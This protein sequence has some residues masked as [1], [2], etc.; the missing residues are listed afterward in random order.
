MAEA[1][2]LP[3]INRVGV[4]APLDWLSLGW[5]DLRRAPF[6][7]L[8]YGAGLAVL[9]MAV[10]ATLYLTGQ[11]TW[12]LVLAGGF[13]II[14]PILGMGL[15]RAACQLERGETPSL[16]SMII[17]PG[18]L[19]TDRIML[20]VALFV[21]FG[22]WVEAA[23]IIYGLSTQVM[24]QNVFDFF[25]FLLMTPDGWQ[26]ALIGSAIGG[27]IAFLA[28]TVVVVSAPMLLESESDFFISVIS[29]ARAVLSNF[30]AML[31][32]ALII[33]LLTV[34]GIATAMVGLVL[35]FPWIGLSSWHAYRAL[36]VSQAA[37][38]G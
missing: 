33:A 12:F 22:I 21:L 30:P 3:G 7:C 1:F 31:L 6:A 2:H 11:F 14:A 34:F 20:G 18:M 26:M 36:V 4:L 17:Q 19:R 27:F 32:W 23:Y 25:H 10:T 35:V 13:L 9:S 38:V 28:F 24:H 15:Y 16:A 29:S 5:R 37:A 8:I